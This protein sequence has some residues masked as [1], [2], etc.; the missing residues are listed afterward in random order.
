MAV[1]KWLDGRVQVNMVV[2]IDILSGCWLGLT[3]LSYLG[4]AAKVEKIEIIMH[5]AFYLGSLTLESAQL[6]SKLFGCKNLR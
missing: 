3:K 6:T 5:A 2:V 4:R 1:F